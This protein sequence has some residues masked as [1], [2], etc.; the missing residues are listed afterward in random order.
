VNRIRQ[1]SCHAL[2]AA[3]LPLCLSL[4]HGCRSGSDTPDAGANVSRY[5][6]RGEITH[7]ATAREPRRVTLRHEPIGDFKNESGALVGMP[8]MVMPFDLAPGVALD[9]IQVGDKVEVRF[10]VSWAP[11]SLKVEELRRLPADVQL[12]FGDTP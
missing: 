1:Y 12:R 3:L 2:V 9:G 5:T 10:A 8:S 6:V 7:L 11:S 4:A